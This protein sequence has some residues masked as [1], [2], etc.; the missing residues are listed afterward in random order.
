[1][2]K[3]L[4]LAVFFLLVSI[5]QSYRQ[6][7]IAVLSSTQAR[8]TRK[9]TPTKKH[10]PTPTPSPIP[11][12]TP[13]PTPTSTPMPTATPTPTS[14]PTPT[15]TPTPTPTP[16]PSM[17]ITSVL[18]RDCSVDSS[19]YGWLTNVF[20]QGYGFSSDS[21]MT[22]QVHNASGTVYSGIYMSGNGSTYLSTD[23]FYLP[24]CSDFSVT[25]AG[26]SGSTTYNQPISSMC[27]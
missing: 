9:P 3:V 17:G 7:D 25:V 13:M 8:P 10:T 12:S 6:T 18:V 5:G 15:A 4:V 11:T 26:S 1:M 19:C 27:P 2:F 22:L 16:T 24:H 21:R 23:F 14:T 20:A